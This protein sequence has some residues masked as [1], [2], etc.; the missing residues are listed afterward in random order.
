MLCVAI[1]TASTWLGS[2]T[3]ARATPYMITDLGYGTYFVFGAFIVTMALWAFLCIPETKG[4]TLEQMDAL[5]AKSTTKA[6][7]AQVRRKPLPIDAV[8]ATPVD[9]EKENVSM[10]EEKRDEEGEGRRA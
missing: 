2:F 6:A 1:T 5:F 3:I 8:G 7:W 4:L 10:Y 9:L